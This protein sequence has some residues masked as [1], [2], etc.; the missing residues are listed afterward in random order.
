ME[1]VLNVDAIGVIIVTGEGH[2][3]LLSIFNWLVEVLEIFLSEH[4]LARLSQLLVS[5]YPVT[6]EV[7]VVHL[8]L[9]VRVVLPLHSVASTKVKWERYP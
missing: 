5:D 1:S 3:D 8:S 4:F 9:V 7:F 2:R 6:F